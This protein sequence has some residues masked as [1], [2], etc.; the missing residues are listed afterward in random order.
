[1]LH[2]NKE[3]AGR[4]EDRAQWL[5]YLEDGVDDPFVISEGECAPV[6]L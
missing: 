4:W 1:M 3:D 2:Y 6:C 5:P